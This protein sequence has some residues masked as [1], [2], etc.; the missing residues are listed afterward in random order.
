M[1]TIKRAYNV[2]SVV[3]VV[4]IVL[5][6]LASWFLNEEFRVLE[7][8]SSDEIV[9]ENKK[10]FSLSTNLRNFLRFRKMSFNKS[11]KEEFNRMRSAC[12]SCKQVLYIIEYCTAID[13]R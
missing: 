9:V 8:A 10:S 11:T 12:Q 1:I 2:I 7:F 6:R 5:S 13:T 3:V 4:V